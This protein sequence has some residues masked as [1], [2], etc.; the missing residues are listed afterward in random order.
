MAVGGLLPKYILVEKTLED[1]LLCTANIYYWQIKLWW[2]DYELSHLTKC[3][4]KKIECHLQII[5]RIVRVDEIYTAI[6]C[7]I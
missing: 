6:V 5:K 1:W 3:C 4:A 2:I 7:I